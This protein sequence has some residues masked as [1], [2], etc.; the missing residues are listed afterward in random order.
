MAF[1]A[2][3]FEQHP[4]TFLETVNRSAQSNANREAEAVTRADGSCW[5]VANPQFKQTAANFKLI[6]QWLDAQG[7]RHSTYPDFQAAY[8]A[9]SAEGLLGIHANVK[10]PRT[11]T[12]PLTGRT[13]DNLDTMIAQER[14]AILHHK[15]TQSEEEI[16]FDN[17]PDEEA[18]A[19]LKQAEKR[20]ELASN[21]IET[22]KNGNAWL[23][24]RP[25]YVD[26]LRNAK[27]MKAQLER[28]GATENTATIE[29]YE[30]AWQKLHA[31]GLLTLNRDV[32]AKQSVA[33]VRQRATE[34]INE[35]GSV[36]DT[37]GED[38]ME[39]LSL[40][41]LR[42]RANRQLASGR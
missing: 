32:L 19:L 5:L 27:L 9:L 12:S 21:G 14:H 3:F 1:D 15:S 6:N 18:L 40:E 28:D 26:S 36:F 31:S 34:A 13:Y 22:T 42:T 17:L 37:T 30:R 8:D 16:A 33:E 29:Q 38:E 24:L 4:D 2:N 35:R 10:P 11:F 7:V 25:E 23:L 39:N 41:E 20:D